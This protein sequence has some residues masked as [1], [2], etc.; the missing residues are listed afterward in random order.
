MRVENSLLLL[1]WMNTVQIQSVSIDLSV[2]T[3]MKRGFQPPLFSQRAKQRDTVTRG[4][5]LFLAAPLVAS[6]S[7]VT[8]ANTRL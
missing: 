5:L 4:L 1:S 7:R 3:K 8:P 2:C 6:W